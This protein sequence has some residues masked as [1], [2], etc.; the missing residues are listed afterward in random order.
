MQLFRQKKRG[1]WPGVFGEIAG[2]L[3]GAVARGRA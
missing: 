1:D 3:R 2:A